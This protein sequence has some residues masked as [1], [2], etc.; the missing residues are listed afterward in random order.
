MNSARQLNLYWGDMHT[1]IHGEHIL[2]LDQTMRA[3]QRI[4]DFFP[5]AYY[6]FFYYKKKGLFIESCGPKKEFL[7]DWKKVQECIAEGNKPEKFITFLGYEWH[8]DRR[9]YGDHNIFYLND[10]QPLDHS[11]TLSQLFE[12]LK[13]NLGIAVPHHTAYQV[14]ERGKDWN[15]HDDNLSPFAEIYS[16]H[17]SSEGCD[18]P[19]SMNKVLK[20]GVPGS[21]QVQFRKALQ[22]AIVWG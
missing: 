16:F 21:P 6:P 15:F 9:R 1:N 20:M 2:T 7:E 14:G 17:G 10:F 11:K 13:K 18:T 19:Y 8:G 12:N 22:E 3:A 4:L 5:I